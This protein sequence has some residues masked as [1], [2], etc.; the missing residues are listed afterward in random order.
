MISSWHIND[1][2]FLKLKETSG[3]P[4]W[5]DRVRTV[6]VEFAPSSRVPLGHLCEEEET[7]PRLM[8]FSEA[9]CRFG[10]TDNDAVVLLARLPC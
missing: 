1:D 8:T 4:L 6:T 5:A 7:R 10:V 9:I 2:D 3:A